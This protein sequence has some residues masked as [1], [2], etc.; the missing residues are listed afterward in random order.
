MTTTQI[1]PEKQ[2]A[3]HAARGNNLFLYVCVFISGMTTLATEMLASRLLGSV[4]GTSNLVWANV[5][6]LMLLYLTIGYTVGGRWADRSPHRQT[7]YHILVWGAFLNALIPLASRPVLTAAAQAVVGAQAALALGSFVSVLVLFAIPIT[8]LGTVSPFAIRLAVRDVDSAGKTSGRIYA[9]STLGSLIGTF[10]PV[11]LLIPELGTFRTFLLFSTL[12]Y[13]TGFTGLWQTRPVSA[14][15]TLWM[16]VI[17]AI[18]S[19][20]VLNGPLRPPLA[21]AEILYEGESAYN[22]IQVQEDSNGNRYLYLNEGQGI[23][24]Q[25]H[26][27]RVAYGRTWDFFLV[28]PYFNEPVHSPD[29]VKS[30]LL[31]GLAAGTIARQYIEVYG[32][33]PIDGIEIDPEIIEVGARFFDMNE[34]HMPSLT[35][36]AQDGRYI[37]NQLDRQ[38]S[39]VG[40]DAYRPPYIPAHLTTVEFFTEVRDHL[41][42]DGVVIINVGRT[43]T[44]RRLVDAMTAT[45]LQVFPS[46]HA[47]DVPYSFNTILVATMLPTRDDNL[48][49]N[50]AFLPDDAH[51]MLRDVLGLGVTSLVPTNPS[52]VIFT[53]DRAPIET[54]VDSL[55]L[56]FL[57][58]GGAEQLQGNN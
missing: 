7:F 49:E 36:Y 25:W 41:T 29:E 51:P 39:V 55:V 47:M 52:D 48:I 34:Q 43:T 23:H 16:P 1:Y 53:D 33:I 22:Y 37:L 31:V 5:I 9:I 26:P 6:G 15:K 8:L 24:S 46:V 30:L 27:E 4:F 2:P 19:L 10:L 54:L 44:D 57:L 13:V 11:L 20:V 14:L 50:L 18:L 32:D 12:L 17:V 40:I 58:S 38:Y 35:A 21:N 56:N 28:G 42:A 3:S 45:L